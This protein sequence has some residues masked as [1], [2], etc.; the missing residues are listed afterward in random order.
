MQCAEPATESSSTPRAG[1]KNATRSRYR[2]RRARSRSPT[3]PGWRAP[4]SPPSDGRDRRHCRRWRRSRAPSAPASKA[5]ARPRSRANRERARRSRC[6]CRRPP[7]LRTYRKSNGSRRRRRRKSAESNECRCPEVPRR[8]GRGPHE[9]VKDANTRVFFGNKFPRKMY[10]DEAYKQ[11]G[12]LR[13]IR[14]PLKIWSL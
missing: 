7:P 2:P 9:A 11:S 8:R 13:L 14:M 4:R 12:L 6:S 10:A 3:G 1:A 5:A